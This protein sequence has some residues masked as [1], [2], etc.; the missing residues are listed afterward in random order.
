STC[1]GRID[2]VAP[3]VRTGLLVPCGFSVRSRILARA[4]P[5]P[6]GGPARRTPMTSHSPI[7]EGRRPA[8]TAGTDEHAGSTNAVKVA[9]IGG[10]QIFVDRTWLLA[11]VFFTWSLGAYYDT[12]FPGW[13]HGTAY[14]IGALSTVLLFVTVLLHELGH[15]FTARA[16]GLPVSSITLF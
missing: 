13:G 8:A 15:S 14:L 16:L 6:A 5:L 1:P 2:D 12:A 11:F 4:G 3:V 10:L 7:I 9:T